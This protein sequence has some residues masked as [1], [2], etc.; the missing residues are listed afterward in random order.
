MRCEPRI[1]S[2]EFAGVQAAKP[3]PG[4]A[5]ALHDTAL[6]GII[7]CPSNP[8]LSIEPI[9][10]VPGVRAAIEARRRDTP[11]VG[12]SPIIGRSSVKGPLAKIFAER[13]Q[14]V[15]SLQVARH[16]AGLVDAWLIDTGDAGQAAA[17]G[18]LG[19]HTRVTP[20]LMPDLYRQQEVARQVLALLQDM[21]NTR[22]PA[23]SGRN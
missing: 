16:Y 11:V 19:M 5:A 18:A 20:I 15:S 12:V 21:R 7:I 3:S 8:F 13:G 4:L 2:L 14:E 23:P 1:D 9:L 22:A 10:A 6:E 17:I